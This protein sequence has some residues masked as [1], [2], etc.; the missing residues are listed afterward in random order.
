MPCE[1]NLVFGFAEYT[2]FVD[3]LKCVWYHPARLR[4]RT[5]GVAVNMRPCQGRDRGFES[6]RVRLRYQTHSHRRT[7]E[8]AV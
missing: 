4:K 1:I 8:R 5:R 3:R 7:S 2:I 6:R